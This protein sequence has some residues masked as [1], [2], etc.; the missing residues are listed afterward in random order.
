MENLYHMMA[1]HSPSM[2]AVMCRHL[3][4]CTYNLRRR[5][6]DVQ[7]IFMDVR[8][9]SSLLDSIKPSTTACSTVMQGQCQLGHPPYLCL[10]C[11]LFCSIEAGLSCQMLLPHWRIRGQAAPAQPQL[12]VHANMV[13]HMPQA[14]AHGTPVICHMSNQSCPSFHQDRSCQSRPQGNTLLLQESVRHGDPFSQT[15]SKLWDCHSTRPFM[16]LHDPEINDKVSLQSTIGLSLLHEPGESA[17][18]AEQ[19]P[20]YLPLQKRPGMGLTED[21]TP[22]MTWLAQQS[23]ISPALGWT[24][25]H[26]TIMCIAGRTRSFILDLT[27]RVRAMEPRQFGTVPC[28]HDPEQGATGP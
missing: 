12:Q 10:A 1:E 21:E 23:F 25:L 16:E 9:S 8:P 22:N 5:E 6:D 7:L 18:I 28:L 3:G 26:H 27:L 24:A 13:C 4:Y 19:L 17:P 2:H 14:T 11:C 15:I 20:T